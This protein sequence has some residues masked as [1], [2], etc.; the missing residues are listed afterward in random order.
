LFAITF[1]ILA[2]AV[3][4]HKESEIPADLYSVAT[5]VGGGERLAD[6]FRPNLDA[7]VRN[8]DRD[9]A[10]SK[11]LIRQM[12]EDDQ[13]AFLRTALPILR[14]H[15]DSVGAQYVVGVLSA[16]GMLVKALTDPQLTREQA[17]A[18]AQTAARM[19][20]N[21]EMV[22]ARALA[23]TVADAD[24]EAHAEEHARLMEILSA[25]SDGSRIFPLLVRLLRHNN[26]H[27]RSKAVLMIGR[28]NR[29]ANWVRQRLAD[30]DPRIRANAA[31]A[32]WGV[33][34]DEAREL[35]QSLVHD[36]NNRVAGNAIA[37]LYRF[38]DQ[39]MI[40]EI[41]A[42]SRHESPVFRS[43][44]A[45]VMGATGDPRFTEALAG[46]L[47]EPHG[48]IRKR[49]FAALG[50]IR[51][52]VAQ[53]HQGQPW[54][55]F[56]R[57]LEPDAV[58]PGRR[59]I[60]GVAREDGTAP[61]TLLATQV[62]LSEEGENVVQYRVVDKPLPETMSVVFVLPRSGA[63]LVRA[64]LPWKRPTDLWGFL[65][66]TREVSATPAVGDGAPRF[67]SSVEAIETELDRLPAA[68]DCGDLWHNVARAVSLD[69]GG[70]VGNRKVILV[71]EPATRPDAGQEL[72][73]ATAGAQ[74]FVQAI[75]FGP[76]RTVEDFCRR[77]GGLY[78]E[79]DESGAIETYLNL[80]ARHEVVYQPVNPAAQSLKVRLHGPGL[81]AEMRLPL[82]AQ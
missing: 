46:L 71:N 3:H 77:A 12:M 6:P 65:Y 69:S 60:F 19:D 59:L 79:G 55:L 48:V 28:G 32:L 34:T 73:S 25:I 36:S 66:Y 13:D 31:E 11:R 23:D 75:S 7:L 15:L 18:L 68:N 63:D 70:M 80:L 9:A 42:L 51:T 26:P 16:S 30:S 41:L 14:A 53:A 57:M 40:Q 8:L 24:P 44:A 20:S 37:G 27:I 74:A 47:R 1:I 2:R 67:H 4:R 81:Y 38:G 43:T 61:P 17:L 54:R 52:A 39:L 82:V 10:R 45:W 22:L 21:A 33:G 56:G 78:R 35:L 64:C 49:A 50:S 76:D 62:L 72:V 58:R 5:R 29:S